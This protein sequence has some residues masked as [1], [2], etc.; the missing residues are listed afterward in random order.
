[1]TIMRR[2]HVI[3]EVCG[4]DENGLEMIIRSEGF[5]EKVYRMYCEEIDRFVYVEFA[6]LLKGCFERCLEMIGM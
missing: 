1:M 4:N 5:D 6:G 2:C 3:I